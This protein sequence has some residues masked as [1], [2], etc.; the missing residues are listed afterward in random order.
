[1]QRPAEELLRLGRAREALDALKDEV[2][3]QPRDAALRYELF[4][5]RSLLGD[6][7]GAE[8]Q[9]QLAVNLDPALAPL[10]GLYLGALRAE[11]ERG[12]VLAG[13]RAP[14]FIG[15][16]PGWAPGFVHALA[17]EAKGHFE[18]AREVRA[19]HLE[20]SS[21]C[22]GRCQVAAGGTAAAFAWL[23]DGDSRFG[24]SLEAIVRGQYRWIPFDRLQRLEK[25]AP[26][27]VADLVWSSVELTFAEGGRSTALVPVR[28]PGIDADG[29]D[30]VALA[31][32]TRWRRTAENSFVGVGQRQLI[33]PALDLPWL[34]IRVLE[35]DR[36]E[37]VAEAGAH[38]PQTG[39]SR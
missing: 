26:S 32:C 11:A 24:P 16:P 25:A 13:V 37:P 6:L 8:S 5:L 31:R 28:Y 9:L 3:L 23:M 2:R 14:V 30:E 1:M 17:L 29:E 34:D 7:A 15:E 36:D 33:G 38:R 4:A 12:E 19:Q 27:D 35:F 22:P 39:P 20:P 21:T 10:A 18:A